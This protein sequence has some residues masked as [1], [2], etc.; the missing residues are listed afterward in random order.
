MGGGTAQGG[1]FKH[2]REG[3]ALFRGFFGS[4]GLIIGAIRTKPKAGPGDMSS[5]TFS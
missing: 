5:G 4:H 2:A 1:D 3:E